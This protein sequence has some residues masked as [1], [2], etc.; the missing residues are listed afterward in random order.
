MSPL[1]PPEE[2]LV[3]LELLV[4]HLERDLATL[5]S[6]LLDQQQEIESLKRLVNRLDDRVTRLADDEEPRD[7][8]DERPPHY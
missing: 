6:V 2:R 8:G 5:N 4:T 1:K 3:T 7:P